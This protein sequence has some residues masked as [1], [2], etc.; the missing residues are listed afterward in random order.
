MSFANFFFSS[1]TA[2]A[3][4]VLIAVCIFCLAPQNGIAAPPELEVATAEQVKVASERVLD[5]RIEA[6]KQSTVSAQITDRV[7]A[8]FFDVDDYVEKGAVLLHFRDKEQRANQDVAMARFQEAKSEFERVKEVYEKKLVARASYDK[9]EAGLKAA[10]ARLNQAT[11]ALE[12]TIVRAPYNG[13]VVKRHI[14]VGET[15]RVG[16]KLMSGISLESLRATTHAP[17]SL[18]ANIRK[19]RKARV[20]LKPGVSVPARS[21]VISPFADAAT[22]T[23]QVRVNLESGQSNIYPGMWVKV[24]FQTGEE[25]RLVVPRD[26]VARRSEVTAVYVVEND[27]LSMRYVRLGGPA[28]DGHVTVLAGLKAGDQVALDP[29]RAAGLVVEQRRGAADE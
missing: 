19:N 14:E 16:Q 2:V 24:A 15:A 27:T 7:E 28:G 8:I 26:A 5:A 23:F 10:R 4:W 22:H 18:I 29:V 11:E 25:A 21:L 12:N 20:I 9:A 6:V 3:R 17:Q 1:S 13:I